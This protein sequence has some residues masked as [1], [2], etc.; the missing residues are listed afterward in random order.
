MRRIVAQKV[1]GNIVKPLAY[2]PPNMRQHSHNS[3]TPKNPDPKRGRDSQTIDKASQSFSPEGE[4]AIESVFDRGVYVGENTSQPGSVRVVRRERT[5]SACAGLF[6][7]RRQS[8]TDFVDG[9]RIPTPKG[10]G[11]LW[12]FAWV[13]S[14]YS[15]M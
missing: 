12:Y 10:A 5:A 14:V 1:L 6:P 8:P 11:I 3:H 13:C 2:H 4:K 9:M 15:L 7:L